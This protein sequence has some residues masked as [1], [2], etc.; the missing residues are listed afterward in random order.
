MI[1]IGD[2]YFVFVGGDLFVGVE[3]EYVGLILGFGWLIMMF[4]IECFVIVFN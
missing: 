1:F 3:F 2:D 4:V